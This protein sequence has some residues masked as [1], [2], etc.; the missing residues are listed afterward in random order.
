MEGAIEK[1]AAKSWPSEGAFMPGQFDNPANPEVHARTTA[2]G[3][4]RGAL[5][6]P[7]HAFVAAVGTGGTVS[8]VGRAL[9]DRA[10]RGG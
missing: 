6:R 7:V 1:C 3:N 2:R 9:D 4:P 5:G 8:G 10:D